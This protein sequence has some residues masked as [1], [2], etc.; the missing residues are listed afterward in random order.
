M[1]REAIDAHDAFRG[2]SFSIYAKGS[3]PNNTNVRADSDV[4]V[5]MQCREV[6]YWEE[7]APGAHG[8][9]TAYS[10]PWT[11]TKLRTEVEAALRAKFQGPVD[12]TGEVAIRVASGTARRRRRGS[13]GSCHSPCVRS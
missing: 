1:V 12:A 5:A 13:A 6:I 9:A 2:Y 7:E 10:G 8:P 3:Y 4:D 11:P